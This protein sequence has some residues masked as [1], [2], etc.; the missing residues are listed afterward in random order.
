MA[1]PGWPLSAWP[2]SATS[3]ARP[4]LLRT[5]ALRPL[6]SRPTYEVD[7]RF[8]LA[9]VALPAIPLGLLVI[10]G[11]APRA[12]AQRPRHGLSECVR[13]D[14][15]ALSLYLAATCAYLRPLRFRRQEG[16]SSRR[17]RKLERACSLPASCTVRLLQRCRRISSMSSCRACGAELAGLIVAGKG[18]C[19]GR[20][21]SAHV[22]SCFIGRRRPRVPRRH[23]RQL[24]AIGQ[25]RAAALHGG[26]RHPRAHARAPCHSARPNP[27]AR[28]RE[29]KD[30]SQLK[31]PSRGVS[32]FPFRCGPTQNKTRLAQRGLRITWRFENTASASY[33]PAR[34]ATPASEAPSG[35]VVGALHQAGVRVGAGS[36]RGLE[37]PGCP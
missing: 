20:L 31:M 22:P 21:A 7:T 27:A 11:S 37:R 29:G 35:E 24:H 34:Q 17:S 2:G 33:R 25:V 28:F 10:L 15:H 30:W 19:D 12:G 1:V 6:A 26:R 3:L 13:F 23:A 18:S 5:R 8:T 9:A 36:G 16:I 14:P 32:Y 4:G